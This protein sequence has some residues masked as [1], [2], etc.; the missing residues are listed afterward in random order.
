MDY[1]EKHDY[2]RHFLFQDL[3]I[4]SSIKRL[5]NDSCDRYRSLHSPSVSC[6]S[7]SSGFL[8][9]GTSVGIVLVIA[10]PR[11]EGAP[12]ISG[13]KLTAFELMFLRLKRNTKC[14]KA[15]NGQL[16]SLALLNFSNLF[17]VMAKEVQAFF[18]HTPPSHTC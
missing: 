2:F 7:A 16:G 12:L 8:W 3:N 14:P 9:I 5:L 18:H 4:E 11:L 6:I 13:K 17:E 1:R 10:L 15:S